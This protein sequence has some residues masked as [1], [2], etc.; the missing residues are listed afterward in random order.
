M[1]L[2][3]V[4]AMIFGTYFIFIMGILWRFYFKSKRKAVSSPQLTATQYRYYYSTTTRIGRQ[5]PLFLSR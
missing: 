2:G 4:L 3:Y 1:D 5:E